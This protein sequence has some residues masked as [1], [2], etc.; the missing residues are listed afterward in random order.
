MY[1]STF[2]RSC[3]TLGGHV[4]VL[5]GDDEGAMLGLTVGENTGATVG[6]HVPT[7]SPFVG[8]YVSDDSR[9][10]LTGLNVGNFWNVGL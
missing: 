1:I 10:V 7:S 2:N 3:P 6:G 8:A 5:E 4:N 9:N